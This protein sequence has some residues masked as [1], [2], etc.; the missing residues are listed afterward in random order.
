MSMNSDTSQIKLTKIIPQT[1][2]QTRL[3]LALSTLLPEY[4][5]ARI[6]EWVKAGYVTVDGKI[7]RSKD[8]VY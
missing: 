1:L 2:D 6:Q 3:D 5:R 4:S 8:K 7:I